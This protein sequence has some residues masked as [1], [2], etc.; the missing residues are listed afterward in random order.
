MVVVVV[1]VAVV[2]VSRKPTYFIYTFPDT[3]GRLMI[4]STKKNPPGKSSPT[5][6]P[7][8]LIDVGL[9]PVEIVQELIILDHAITIR[10]RLGLLEVQL[11]EPLMDL[12]NGQSRLLRGSYV[13][14]HT[15]S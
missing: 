9:V 13:F 15:I 7:R 10:I 12:V 6:Q 4:S 3:L 1:V 2:V 14:L 5:V 11:I 8:R